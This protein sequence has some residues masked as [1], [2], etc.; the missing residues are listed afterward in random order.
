[1]SDSD[2]FAQQ[3]NQQVETPP[4]ISND[5]F[6][7]KL[8][9]IKNENGEPKYK[10][11]ATA[12]DALIASQQFIETLKSEKQQLLQEKE[13]LRIENEEMASVN[14]LINR[15]N[16]PAEP[17]NTTV[18]AV[19]KGLSE[20]DIAKLLEQ[21]LAQRDQEKV[22]DQNLS[23]VI[24]QLSKVYGDQAGAHIQKR[25]QELNTTTDSLRELA[26]ANPQMALELLAVKSVKIPVTPS[27]SQ[28]VPPHTPSDDNPVPSW[29]RGAARGGLSNKELLNRWKQST[30]FTNKRIGLDSN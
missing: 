23:L 27:Q 30:A 13:R 21:K 10:D 9:G 29:D 22:R 17:P 3:Q 18:T 1:M 5:P 20:D 26:R 16:P 7:D 14:D 25:A 12:L 15:L 8:M 4:I 28:I 6:A 24:G 19:N 2:I 11:V